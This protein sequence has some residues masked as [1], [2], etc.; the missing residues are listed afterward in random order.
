MSIVYAPNLLTKGMRSM[1]FE[2]LAQEDT[3]LIQRLATVV[4]SN[5]N[6]EDY[7]WLDHAP[8]MSL[9]DNDELEFTG[10]GD[11][12]YELVNG[13]YRSGI[14]VDRE[15]L[16]DDQVGGFPFRIQQM[17]QVA[18]RNPIKLL[19]AALVN[20]ESQTCIDG[21][22]FFSSSHPELGPG[23]AGYSNIESGTSGTTTANIQ[24]QLNAVLTK[25]GEYLNKNGEPEYEMLR[26][27]YIVAPWEIRGA[28]KEALQATI[29]SNTSN[30]Q[31]DDITWDVV[32]SAR[33]TTATKYYVGVQDTA[34]K[35]LILQ[36]R[37]PLEFTAQDMPT[38]DAN[39]VRDE[40][41]YKV[42]ARHV[43]GYGDPRRVVLVDAS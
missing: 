41:R 20:G 37:R 7:A 36:D 6:K 31:F 5:A 16:E 34:M 17:A 25:F 28:V 12:T 42:S 38:D 30:V 4:P 10:M 11:A 24:T 40:Y 39:F 14:R 26:R 8:Q 22:N 9:K 33:L 43:V 35:G 23:P 32:F 1:F 27:L 18:A 2:A 29:I 21:G 3:S 15:D 19:M 13:T